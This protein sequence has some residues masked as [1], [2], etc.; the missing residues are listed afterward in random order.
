MMGGREAVKIEFVECIRFLC[1]TYV[2]GIQDGLLGTRRDIVFGHGAGYLLSL[3]EL[4]LIV[5]KDHKMR[6]TRLR[7]TQDNMKTQGDCG[8]V[9]AQTLAG[10]LWGRRGSDRTALLHKSISLTSSQDSVASN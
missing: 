10:E 5:D 8:T 7:W 9:N 1:E 4:N 6:P 3:E 2:L